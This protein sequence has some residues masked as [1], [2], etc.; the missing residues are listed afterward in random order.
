MDLPEGLELKPSPIHGV[1]VFT[2]RFFNKDEYMG[3]FIG[4]R[5]TKPEFKERYGDDISYTYWSSHN[6]KTTKVSVAKEPRNFITYI[7]E[8]GE[9]NVYLKNY[10]LW[11]GAALPVGQELF[12]RYANSYPRDYVLC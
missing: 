4:E 7:N 1:G 10:K 12:L 6:F 11:A 8:R 2:T 9:P 5:M 3:D